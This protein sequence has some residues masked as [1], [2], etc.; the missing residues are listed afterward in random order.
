MRIRLTGLKAL[1]YK[2]RR[3][4]WLVG[5]SVEFPVWGV[6]KDGAMN[7]RD[8]VGHGLMGIAGFW[9]ANHFACGTAH[10]HPAE[11]QMA[12]PYVRS[13][14]PEFHVPPYRGE[15]YDDE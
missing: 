5:P 11:T 7:R 6:G 2:R 12:I 15:V 14:I 1:S 13:S 4:G 9:A 3:F 10:A 8:F